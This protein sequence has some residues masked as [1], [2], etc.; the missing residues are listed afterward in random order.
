[1][2][3]IITIIALAGAILAGCGHRTRLIR[4][5]NEVFVEGLFSIWGSWV[6]DE[7]ENLDVRIKIENNAPHGILIRT[8]DM[9]CSR[10]DRWGDLRII[11]GHGQRGGDILF[12]PGQVHDFTMVCD[13]ARE[14]AG[15]FRIHV[16]HVYED[17]H[18]R[19]DG[20][21]QLLA[22]DIEWMVTEQTLVE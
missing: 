8:R 19:P 4:A 12:Q 13:L 22:T 6:K 18:D 7:G 11:D 3:R 5:E 20:A 15:E 17:P 9:R 14:T 2:L 16:A 10:G 21:A 1:M